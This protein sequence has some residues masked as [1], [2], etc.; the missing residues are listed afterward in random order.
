M[1]RLTDLN[2]AMTDKGEGVAASLEGEVGT[3]GGRESGGTP[4]EV[5]IKVI[6]ESLD[7]LFSRVEP[8]VIRGNKFKYHARWGHGF[9]VC[10]QFL[11]VQYLMFGD[12][13]GFVHAFQGLCLRQNK[14]AAGVVLE[15]FQPHH[16]PKYGM[17]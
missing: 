7:G 2:E 12:N 1:H 6:L 10:C 11:I 15:G 13:A 17:V 16:K 5:A 4:A 8:M 14:F 9:L 3:R